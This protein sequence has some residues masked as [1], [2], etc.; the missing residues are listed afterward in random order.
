MECSS[1]LCGAIGI[2]GTAGHHRQ[3][4]FVRA[5]NGKEESNRLPK[6]TFGKEYLYKQ[7]YRCERKYIA[8][9]FS[10]RWKPDKKTI[11]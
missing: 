9:F 1:S 11:E 3:K 5:T 10:R 8:S 6:A 4:P 7:K 2:G